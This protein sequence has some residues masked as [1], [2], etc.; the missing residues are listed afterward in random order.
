MKFTPD[1]PR[2]SGAPPL[3]GR[4]RAF[5]RFVRRAP[6]YLLAGALITLPAAVAAIQTL[7][8][9][10]QLARVAGRTIT[11]G[12]VAD[13][14]FRF[15]GS[16]GVEHLIN[17]ELIEAEAERLKV[18]V[19]EAE[20]DARIAELREEA[21]ARLAEMLKAEGITE[22][23]WRERNGHLL[24]AR[25]VQQSLWPVT[26]KDLNR[27]SLRYGRFVTEVVAREAI[28]S[29]RNG[30]DFELLVLQRSIDKENGGLLQPNPF[31]RVDHPAFFRMAERSNLRDGQ[32][33]RQPIKSGNY[34]L[35]LKQE[36]SFPGSSLQGKER[37]EAIER[38]RTFR[39]AR[40]LP[41]LRGKYAIERMMT[42]EELPGEADARASAVLATV[43]ERKIRGSDLINHLAANYGRVVLDALVGR[44][45]LEKEASD[46]SVAVSAAD[47]TE[48]EGR[49]RK[50]VGDDG[51]KKLLERSGMNE[52]GWREALR[53]EILSEKVIDARF[54]PDPAEMTRYSADYLLLPR[55]T[56]AREAIRLAAATSFDDLMKQLG[57][58]AS[59]RVQPDPFLKIENPV[60]FAAIE[61]ANVG[62]G[63]IV[64]M[65]VPVAR[66]YLVLRLVRKETAGEIPPADR[67]FVVRRV[68]APRTPELLKRLRE[69]YPVEYPTAFPPGP[70][71][72]RATG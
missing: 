29:A 44:A 50:V 32:I 46:L 43:G 11:Y 17:Q 60:L 57:R 13:A 14:L 51:F 54:P 35:V 22:E 69:N 37:E 58:T 5:D 61:G 45:V 62:P 15:Y 68:N 65:P 49:V 16:V 21:G 8:G 41:R 42:V 10:T 47:L 63:Q 27:L 26:D 64:P 3:D 53:Y 4:G 20:L 33:T 6:L 1:S 56:L 72:A 66:S 70:P 9:T 52:Q 55:E 28:T 19:T 12:Q 71:A 23:V 59:G 18:E 38:V 36:G 39:Q 67:P 25:E 34:Y 7:P 24:L 31:L 2:C 48:R 40:L 30:V